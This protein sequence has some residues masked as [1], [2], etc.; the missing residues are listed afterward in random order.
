MHE[1]KVLFICKRG[2]IYG[3]VYGEYSSG[4]QSSGLKN[5]AAFM[6]RV[7]N[8]NGVEAKLVE[9]TDNNG[10]DREVT[11]YRPTH[12][13]IEALWVVPSKFEVLQR[14]HPRVR[15]VVRI[16]SEI[17][18]L[19][20]EGSAMEWI[21]GYLARGIEVTPNSRRATTA[22]RELVPDGQVR[23]LPNYYPTGHRLRMPPA[24]PYTVV[25][26][27]CFGAV[28]PMKNQ[29]LQAIA[30]ISF[31][32][33]RG[34]GL[35]FHMN[36]TR[37][38][39]GGSPVL[40]NITTLFTRGDT[41]LLLHPWLNHREF[42]RLVRQMDIAMQVSFSETF[43]ITAADAA[44]RGVPVVVSPE[45]SWGIPEYQAETTSL[46]SIERRLEVAYDS[47]RGLLPVL[48]FL[49]LRQASREAAKIWLSWLGKP[50]PWW[51]RWLV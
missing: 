12:V 5:S 48:N 14:L 25:D 1:R 24:P 43:N 47:R 8:A 2:G 28:R 17:P 49:A 33:S 30:A 11:A 42:T 39:Q 21:F 6:V 41:K 10:I 45:I 51:L 50:T 26:I 40:R 4:K 46:G 38:E 34:L 20:Q 27:G 19:A 37:V 35:R 23:Y 36:G 22:L 18:F 31:A 9:V 7:L 29:L 16:H 13:I 32:R 44:A 3:G 15:W